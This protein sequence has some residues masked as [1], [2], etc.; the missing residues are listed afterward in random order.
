MPGS[1]LRFAL[2]G[3]ALGRETFAPPPAGTSRRPDAVV[4]LSRALAA[5]VR[6][7]IV[8]DV[9]VGA[10]LSGGVDSSLVVELMRQDVPGVETFAVGFPS[11]VS[12][13]ID[14]PFPESCVSSSRFPAAG[15]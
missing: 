12:M 11:T 6:R 9:P 7:Q 5:A 10:F 14:W 3:T 13:V 2:D 1:A 8:S 4:E 15:S